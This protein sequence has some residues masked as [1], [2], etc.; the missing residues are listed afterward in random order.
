MK[1]PRHPLRSRAALAGA[2]LLLLS[3][4]RAGL[5]GEWR[6]NEPG[7]TAHDGSGHGYELVMRRDKT[8]AFDG[9]SRDGGGVSGRPGDRAFDPYSWNGY[10]NAHASSL[11]MIPDAYTSLERFT[12]VA[13]VRIN[14]VPKL[15][16][17]LFLLH[18]DNRIKITFYTRDDSGWGTLEVNGRK[19]G[20]GVGWLGAA[21]VGRWVNIAVTYDSALS[22]GAAR[23][24][25]GD[26]AAAISGPFAQGGDGRSSNFGAGGLLHVTPDTGLMIGN[27]HEVN[28]TWCGLIDEVRMFDTALDAEELDAL[29]LKALAGP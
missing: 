3:S 11:G 15:G 4:A 2:A 8:N 17:T 6:F 1:T 7:F 14:R 10:K 28:R 20:S 24:Y 16:E 19:F 26:A 21:D 27:V 29:R 18:A 5:I 12:V 13:W 9:H 22:V 23:F 25:R